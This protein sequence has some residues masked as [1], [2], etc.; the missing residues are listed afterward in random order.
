MLKQKLLSIRPHPSAVEMHIKCYTFLPWPPFCVYFYPILSAT[1]KS[2]KQNIKNRRQEKQIPLRESK[3][4]HCSAVKLGWVYLRGA[5]KMLLLCTFTR[6]PLLYLS[7]S[8]WSLF[9]CSAPCW[10]HQ[11]W[12]IGENLTASLINRWHP[13]EKLR[14]FHGNSLS[15][16]CDSIRPRVKQKT[17]VRGGAQSEKHMYPPPFEDEVENGFLFRS[18]ELDAAILRS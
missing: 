7:S 3:R 17:R 14:I 5:R 9:Q 10:C 1:T 6:S 18:T 13:W 8:R 11:Q 2:T 16:E 15:G 12:R 4:F